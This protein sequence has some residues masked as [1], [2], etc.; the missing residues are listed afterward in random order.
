MGPAY[1]P[2]KAIILGSPHDNVKTHS[3]KQEVVRIISTFWE[4][5]NLNGPKTQLIFGTQL[6]R[7]DREHA[8]P[9]CFC[10]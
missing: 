1:Y 9:E 3:A 4:S 8:S 5:F 2:L 10:L 7:L 6:P